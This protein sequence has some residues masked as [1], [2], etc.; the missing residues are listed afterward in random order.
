[1]EKE[2]R[3]RWGEKSYYSLDYY[4]KEQFGEKVYKIAL[5]GQMSCPNRDGTLGK[6]GCIF[7]S[8]GGSGDFAVPPWGSVTE[9]LNRGIAQIKAGKKAG[10]KFIAYFQAYTNTYAPVEYLKK[11]F[12]EAISHPAVAALSIATR[13]DCLPEDVLSLLN[14]LNKIKPV[15]VELGLQTANDKTAEFLRRGYPCSVFEKAVWDLKHISVETVVHVIIGLPYETKKELLNTIAY[16]SSLPVNGVKL[17][18][19]HILQETDLADWFLKCPPEEF[20]VLSMEEY[21]ELLL[22]CVEHLPQDMV[23]HRITGDGPKKILLE[24][25]WSGNKKLVMNTIHKAMRERGSFQGKAL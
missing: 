8:A 1:M 15:W 16:I 9:Q 12:E 6:R 3:R 22:T 10:N 13:P 11:L 7:C 5:D 14:N 25:Q 17:Q 18:L 24:P 4:L 2:K 19:L 23:I 21:V 20:H